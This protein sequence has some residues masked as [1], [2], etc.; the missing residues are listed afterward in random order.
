MKM[1]FK[2]WLKYEFPSNEII[3][4]GS[5]VCGGDFPVQTSYWNC[6]TKFKEI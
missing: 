1:K 6:T 3:A 4:G 5:S 2:E